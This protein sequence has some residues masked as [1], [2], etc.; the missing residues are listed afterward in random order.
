M[1]FIDTGFIV[2][3]VDSNDQW[4]NHAASLVSKINNEKRVIC[5]AVII[6]SLNTIG[7]RLGSEAIKQLYINLK[8][9]FIIYN[10]NRAL[11]DKAVST[12][13][14]Y[15]G[16]LSLADSIIIEIMKEL[17]ITKIVSFDHHFDNKEKIVR[18]AH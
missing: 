17:N 15:G 18:I 7:K 1:I 12:Q 8:E 2:G 11:Y 5:N 6:E 16:K 14:K 10:E 4:H 9:N 13:I 3:L